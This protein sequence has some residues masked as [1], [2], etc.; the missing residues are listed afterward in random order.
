MDL[1]DGL[2]PHR[3]HGDDRV[4]TPLVVVDGS[5]VETVTILLRG[6]VGVLCLVDIGGGICS[7]DCGGRGNAQY[8]SVS[9]VVDRMRGECEFCQLLDGTYWE[10]GGEAF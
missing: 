4:A 8:D 6:I 5:I 3:C 7:S 2:F 10:G 1:W 9:N